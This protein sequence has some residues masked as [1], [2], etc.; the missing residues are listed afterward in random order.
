MTDHLIHGSAHRPRELVV[1]ERGRV[2]VALNALVVHD[3]V[4]LDRGDA[5]P[6]VRSRNVEHLPCELNKEGNTLRVQA[7]RKEGPGRT[8]PADFAHALDLGGVQD[9]TLSLHPVG[10]LFLE[11]NTVPCHRSIPVDE[12]K[13]WQDEWEGISLVCPRG[14]VEPTLT[15]RSP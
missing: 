3:L 8:H 4:N 11:R 6:N 9:P 2:R 7:G 1:P 14:K 13:R 15:S 5:W 10:S 12:R